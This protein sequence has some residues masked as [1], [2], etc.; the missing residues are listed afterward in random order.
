MSLNFTNHMDISQFPCRV[1]HLA[2]WLSSDQWAAEEASGLLWKMLVDMKEERSG[3]TQ[4]FLRELWVSGRVR[5]SH[6]MQI[7][8]RRGVRILLT[9][10]GAAAVLEY[11][12]HRHPPL[13]PRRWLARSPLSLDCMYLWRTRR[14]PEAHMSQL[15]DPLPRVVFLPP[16]LSLR[17]LWPTPLFS[18]LPA[19]TH[20][21]S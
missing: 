13:L 10:L 11:P 8:D 6:L 9:K 4:V 18:R 14:Q 12:T 19:L 20:G 21:S 1:T 3:H 16:K 15:S 7:S 2:T 5:T 17:S